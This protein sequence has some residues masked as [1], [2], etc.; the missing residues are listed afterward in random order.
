MVN[1]ASTEPVYSQTYLMPWRRLV[2][3]TSSA[4]KNKYVNELKSLAVIWGGKRNKK[5]ITV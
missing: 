3:S 4:D 1:D 5:K 2:T